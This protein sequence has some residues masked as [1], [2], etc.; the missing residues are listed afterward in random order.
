[1]AM[2]YRVRSPMTDPGLTSSSTAGTRASNNPPT[3]GT[4]HN[5]RRRREPVRTHHDGGSRYTL[6]RPAP[7]NADDALPSTGQGSGREVLTLHENQDSN[8]PN[9]D[10]RTPRPRS[11]PTQTLHQPKRKR[12]QIK[13]VSL[14]INGRG[15]RAQDKWGSIG[16][17][18]KR[19]KIAI[20]G[21]QETHPDEE[22]Q[23]ADEIRF[24]NTLRML[25]SADPDNPQSSNGV[26]IAINK[27]LIDAK[28]VTHRMVVPGRVLI[29]EIP[30]NEHNC[31]RIMNVYAPAK[32][33][34]KATFW[35]AY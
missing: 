33:E 22:T 3:V 10:E 14:N 6:Q 32:S 4:G 12:K 2:P 20:L 16:T 34:E 25:H 7:T 21:L 1:M 26:S 8:N 18:M 28:S 19:H 23:K 15:T 31:L 24:R 17:M 27:G 11:E 30:W 13:I 9:Q 35:K 29:I 5:P